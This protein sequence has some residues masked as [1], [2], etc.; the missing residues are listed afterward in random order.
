MAVARRPQRGATKLGLWRLPERGRNAII[1]RSYSAIDACALGITRPGGHYERVAY[2]QVCPRC[3]EDFVGGD[4]DAVAQAVVTHARTE[5][6][7]TLDRDVV[8]A[9]LEGVH[10]HERDA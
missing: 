10:P 6:G 2:E 3:G 4:K 1:G 9:H 8:L 7:H 5:H